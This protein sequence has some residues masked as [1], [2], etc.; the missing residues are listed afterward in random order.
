M[1]IHLTKSKTN[2][3]LPLINK[4]FIF[5]SSTNIHR[6]IN[7]G[8]HQ[9]IFCKFPRIPHCSNLASFGSIVF[10]IFLQL[11]F[12]SSPICLSSLAICVWLV[13]ANKTIIIRT[14]FWSVREI[15]CSQIR[16]VFT[17]IQ[18]IKEHKDLPLFFAIFVCLHPERKRIITFNKWNW[19]IILVPYFGI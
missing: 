2:D 1:C 18:L 7:V 16:L 4:T 8:K 6:F 5:H 13:V 17:S 14:D 11:L 12:A 19:E 15:L 3:N 9:R 10:Q